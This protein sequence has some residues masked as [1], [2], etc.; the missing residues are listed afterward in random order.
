MT[1]ATVSQKGK[2]WVVRVSWGSCLGRSEEE[3]EFATFK[4]AYS[5]ARSSSDDVKIDCYPEWMRADMKAVEDEI[6]RNEHEAATQILRRLLGELPTPGT[7]GSSAASRRRG[8][9][10]GT[11]LGLRT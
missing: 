5:A 1:K 6:K 8:S 10:T 9:R 7:R 11:K 4:K 3:T 2:K